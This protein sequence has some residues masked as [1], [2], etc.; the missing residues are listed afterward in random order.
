MLI[1]KNIRNEY[2][3]MKVFYEKESKKKKLIF[4]KIFINLSTST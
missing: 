2:Y 3:F 1:F 4:F